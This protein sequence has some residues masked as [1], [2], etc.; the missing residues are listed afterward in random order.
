MPEKRLLS[1]IMFSDIEGYTRMMEEAKIRTRGPISFCIANRDTGEE[2]E[3]EAGQDYP[4]NPQ[5][6]GAIKAM[7]GVVLVEEV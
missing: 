5:V 4:V 2:V 3:V 1:A 6:K 7:P